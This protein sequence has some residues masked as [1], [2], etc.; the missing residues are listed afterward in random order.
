MKILIVEDDP[1]SQ[2]LL[3]KIVRREGYDS[4]QVN[5]GKTAWEEINKEK[6]DMVITDWMMPEMDGLQLCRKIRQ[7]NLSKYVYV[8]LL[9]SKDQTEDAVA[10]LDAGADD[11]IKKPFNPDELKARILAGNR[12]IELEDNQKKANAQ[13]L[14]SEKM[15]SIGQLAAGVAHEINNP[16][17]FVSS[18]LK[19]LTD[20]LNDLNNL[21]NHYRKLVAD[22][23]DTQPENLSSSI[24]KQ[25]KQIASLEDEADIDFILE[26]IMD[27]ISDCKEGAV[28]IKKIVLDL[29]DFAHPGEDKIQSADINDGIETTLS[30]VWNELKYK[31]TVNKELGKL[32]MVK[33]YPQQLNQVFM[34]LFVN[35]AQAIEKKGEINI[36]TH[37]DNGFVEIKI[38]DTG[39]GIDQKN[40]DRIFDPF[41]TT[42][43]VGKGTG[44]GLNVA[45]NII[46]KHRG[47]IEVKSQLGKGTV[48]KIRIPVEGLN[49]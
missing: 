5:D 33:C 45:Y 29:K 39:S 27:L 24:E 7:A 17:G 26:D 8:I 48:F 4:V 43:D 21:I 14:Q 38:G 22:L 3:E 10:A 6:F 49:D 23:Q 31:A 28:R 44:L 32:P 20:Y 42:K 25:L 37:A 2:K 30:V 41:F 15:A 47:T 36:S 1:V 11:Y 13:L 18:N 19:T 34:N 40:L 12:I 46:K 35:G 16:T 9:T